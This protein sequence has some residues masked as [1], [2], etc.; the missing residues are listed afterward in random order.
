MYK[1][2][3]LLGGALMNRAVGITT[4]Y[5]IDVESEFTR[6]ASSLIQLRF[7]V[8]EP[9]FGSQAYRVTG[10]SVSATPELRRQIGDFHTNV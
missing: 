5:D 2:Y 1:L 6:D 9:V 3:G 7:H 4:R 10:G 8:R